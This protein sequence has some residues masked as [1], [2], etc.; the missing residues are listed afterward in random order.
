M[1]E[2]GKIV[3]ITMDAIQSLKSKISFN[4]DYEEDFFY[5]VVGAGWKNSYEL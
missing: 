3:I 2:E 1:N 4:A 5:A